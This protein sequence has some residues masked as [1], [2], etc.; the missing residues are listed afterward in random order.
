VPPQV[1]DVMCRL[2]LLAWS[3]RSVDAHRRFYPHS[4]GELLTFHRII[5]HLRVVS[6]F[7]SE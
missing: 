2:G 6:H 7:G 1:S 3:R 4:L 5:V